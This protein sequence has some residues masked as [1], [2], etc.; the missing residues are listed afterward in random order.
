MK[1]K[2]VKDFLEF[3]RWIENVLAYPVGIPIM[4]PFTFDNCKSLNISF[5]R[6]FDC[7][8]NLIAFLSN[9]LKLSWWNKI[10]KYAAEKL[11][12]YSVRIKSEW[13]QSTLIFFF[14]T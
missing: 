5:I 3:I 12:A 6:L 8:N 10:K 11:K 1:E 2:H 7:A 4:L 14:S 9:K 13:E